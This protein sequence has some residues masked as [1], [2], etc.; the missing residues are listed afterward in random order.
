[1]VIGLKHGRGREDDM[2]AAMNAYIRCGQLMD[3]FK[4]EFGSCDCHDLTGGVNFL[5]PEQL[6][7]YYPEGHDRC[8]DM[9]AR[10]AAKLAELME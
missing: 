1:M 3:W 10:T 8:V 7:A 9:A 4:E 5:D 2:S 6:A